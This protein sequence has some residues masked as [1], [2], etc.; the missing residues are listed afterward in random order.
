L[1]REQ[2][3]SMK[4]VV[5]Q[6]G[7]AGERAGQLELVAGQSSPTPFPLL[8][9]KGGCVPHLTRETMAHINIDK[10]P[11]L[12]PFQ[13][14]VKQG[15]VLEKWGAGLASFLGMP[16]HPVVLTIQDP[17]E[18]T[19]SGYHNNNS[20]SVWNRLNRELVTP[21]TFMEDVKH[22]Q[23]NLFLALCDGDTEPGCSNK[24]VSKSVAKSIDFLDSC[25]HLRSYDPS[26]TK[27]GIIGAI[28]GG[29]DMKARTKS[30]KEVVAREVDG[31]LLDGFHCNGPDSELLKFS[32]MRD[33]LAETISLLPADK[34]RFYFG[35]ADPAM[36]FNLTKE[37]VDIF[38]TS[39]PCLVT[40][41]DSALVFPNVWNVDSIDKVTPPELAEASPPPEGSMTQSLACT[42]NRLAFSPLVPGCTCYVCR[43][44]T[45]AYI[46]HL[47]MVKEMLGRVLLQLHNLHHYKTFFTSIQVAIKQD[48]VEEFKKLV[49]GSAVRESTEP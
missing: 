45:R 5:E 28:E 25:L 35:A 46:H 47:V 26:L 34:P 7:K 24:R 12:V 29:L 49:L 31:F 33:V 37:G 4:F 16:E 42:S 10:N 19:R 32:S 13:H 17:G 21:T 40:E 44:F 18:V 39:Y 8:L 36:V 3:R 41:R 43:N 6:L 38:D 23:P 20:V 14:H 2:D 48:Q 1:V 30:T 11:L 15:K 9:T 27:M 22:I